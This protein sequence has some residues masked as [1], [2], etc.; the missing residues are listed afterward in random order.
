MLLSTNSF[1]QTPELNEINAQLRALFEPLNKPTPPKKFLY[2]MSAHSTDSTWYVTNC[3][4]TNYTDVWYKVY[5]EM[6][7]AAYDTSWLT[8]IDSIIASVNNN[9]TDTIPIGIINYAY[10]GLM[11]EA[12]STDTYFN[13][14]TVNNV[15]TDKYPRPGY[16]Y[17]DNN[18]LFMSAPLVNQANFANPIFVIDPKYFYYDSFNAD[19]F[20]KT[21]TLQINFADGTGWHNYDPTVISYYQPNYT[22]TNTTQPTISVRQI[23][24]ATNNIFG[25][26][27]SRFTVGAVANVPPDEILQLPGLLAGVYGG[28]NTT[29]AT[30]KT[31]IYVEGLDIFDFIPNSARTV[32]IIY[33][34]MLRND[35]IIELKNQGYKFV[36]V[37]WRNSRVDMRFN[38]L[39]LVNLLQVLK[40]RSTD[41][42][43]FIVMGESMGGVVARFALT[44][45]ESRAYQTRDVRPFFT[46]QSDLQ[47]LTY[48]G[49]NQQIFT[50]PTNWIEPE[51]MH[52]TRLF[53]S[54]D[55]PHRGASV[56]LSIQ[57]AY[58]GVFGVF[59]TYIGPIL[60]ATTYAYNI[61]LD[62][63][64]A[65]QL[66]I[67][68]VSTESGL[69]FNKTYTSSPVRISFMNQLLAMGSYPQF[70]K[71]MLMSNGALSGASQL[72]YYTNA[73]R[74]GGD[75]LFYFKLDTYAKVLWIKVPLFGGKVDVRTNP[76]GNGH[77]LGANAGTFRVKIKLKWF[78]VRIYAD[79]NSLFNIQHYAN[80][81]PYNT[82][83]GSYI[84]SQ[85]G[86]VGQQAATNSSFNLS[87]NYWLL[88]LFSFSNVNDGQGC[89]RFKS[90]VGF[91]GLASANFDYT[92]CTDGPYFGFI[93]VQ[94]A[95]DYG[96]INNLGLNTNI[97][98]ENINNKLANIPERVDVIVGNPGAGGENNRE[99][100]RYRNDDILNV[101][102]NIPLL[103]NFENTY[104]SCINQTPRV[105]RGILNL[106]IGDEELYLENNTLTYNAEYQVEY[107]MHVNERNRY[108]EYAG[109][110]TTNQTL[111][112]IYSK[113]DLYTIAN[114]GF[115]T[116]IYDISGAP[117]NNQGFFGTTA[118]NFALINQPLINCCINFVGARGAAP[119]AIK[120]IPK[121]TNNSYLTLSPNPN[122]GQF[123][124]L[125]YQF[126]KKGNAHLSI[127][128]IMGKQVYNNSIYIP[129]TKS[130]IT[131][132]IDLA[133]YKLPAGVY[134]VRLTNGID[135]L[136]NKMVLIK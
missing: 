133:Q 36:V 2:E 136:T 5:D 29:Q 127:V 129:T 97:E 37:D 27:L 65:K 99:H 61:F 104:F 131:S 71:V 91:N 66:L 35:K 84:G 20:A 47:S 12:M 126:V 30:G 28:C 107:D 88:N 85:V 100:L 122:N 76:A 31:V 115:A 124:T 11:P 51:K 26:A 93:P 135:T 98:A 38:A 110:L 19:K 46:E 60:S 8:T 62:G 3:A 130:S 67:E 80:T 75:R 54:I 121:A 68:H 83:A 74:T 82:S 69:G 57:K 128:D 109:V 23:N 64:A 42:E 96:A 10:Y 25:T 1:A 40:Q 86:I 92:L 22:T 55:A 16:P 14:D 81:R 59:G 41:N 123:I 106:E 87:N 103:P 95:L 119:M 24:L 90:H 39:Y 89:V 114:T 52:N 132:N 53:I 45:M 21:A 15:L 48:L 78:G 111:R 34:E 18:T 72:N 134:F 58:K 118:G 6:Y 9:G 17:L 56:P 43:Q 50:L 44:Y 13:F 73:P 33:N 105:R 101:S 120:N 7:H 77:I 49:N 125:N 113:R 79:Y 63:K 4:D 94:S 116:F 102:N 112:G 70:A 108:Y 32:P 117:L